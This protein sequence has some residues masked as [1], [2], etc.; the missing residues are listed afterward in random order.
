MFQHENY[1]KHA[2]E[3]PCV[4]WTRKILCKN[5]LALHRYRDFRAGSFYCDSPCRAVGVLTLASSRS[6]CQIS[7]QAHDSLARGVDKIGNASKS[8]QWPFNVVLG[9]QHSLPCMQLTPC[10]LSGSWA[11]GT[12]G[13]RV[14][15][16]AHFIDKWKQDAFWKNL[17]RN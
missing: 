8:G 2:Y 12:N 10:I 3:V 16:G 11:S 5:I 15:M 14:R 17:E 4:K 13:K 6:K 9:R 7:R 1:E